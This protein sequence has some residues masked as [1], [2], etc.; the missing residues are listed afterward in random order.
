MKNL[1]NFLVILI[2]LYP[3]YSDPIINFKS[4][5]MRKNENQISSCISNR[6]GGG[7]G[8]SGGVGGDGGTKNYL[9][10]GTHIFGTN[11]ILAINP[12]SIKKMNFEEVMGKRRKKNDVRALKSIKNQ[13]RIILKS[14][15]TWTI[16]ESKESEDILLN[17]ISFRET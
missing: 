14:S 10:G 2:L 16:N 11:I 13:N 1:P 5:S 6:N 4:N 12:E 8:G 7:G 17:H 15:K 9:A 3:V